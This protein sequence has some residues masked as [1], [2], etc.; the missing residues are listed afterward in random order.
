MCAGAHFAERLGFSVLLALAHPVLLT[1]QFPSGGVIDR[2]YLDHPIGSRLA[3]VNGDALPD[4][5][6]WGTA[7]ARIGWCKNWGAAGWSRTIPLDT[8]ATP[9]VVDLELGDLDGDVDI[10]MVFMTDSGSV[11]WAAN[12]GS[13]AMGGAVLVLPTENLA[14]YPDVDLA[15]MDGDQ[16]LDIVFTRGDNGMSGWSANDG[17]G[18]FGAVSPY[19]WDAFKIVPADM[20]VDGDID[21]VFS[22]G[23]TIIWQENDGT[24]WLGTAHSIYTAG[25]TH[26]WLTVGDIDQDQDPDV[27]AATDA[28]GPDP[29]EV[30]LFT[31]TGNGQAWS[32]VNI[33]TAMMQHGDPELADLNADGDLDLICPSEYYNGTSWKLRI[34]HNNGNGTFGTPTQLSAYWPGMTRV[35]DLDLDGDLDLVLCDLDRA[36]VWQND[37]TAAFTH[38]HPLICN[39]GTAIDYLDIADIDGDGDL[40]GIRSGS[41]TLEWHENDGDQ[42]HDTVNYMTFGYNTNNGAMPLLMHDMDDDGDEDLVRGNSSN[43][44]LTWRKNLGGGAF[45]NSQLISSSSTGIRHLHAADLDGDGHDDLIV[46]TTSKTQWFKYNAADTLLQLPSRPT[47][48]NGN[49]L[50]SFTADLDLD[51]DLDVITCN[52]TG[53]VVAWHPNSGYNSVQLPAVNIISTSADIATVKVGDLDQDGDPDIVYELDAT[54]EVVWRANSG[55]GL[56]AT[57]SMLITGPDELADIEV[58]DR[59]NDGDLDLMVGVENYLT[60][61]HWL[62]MAEN[63]GNAQFGPLTLEVGNAHCPCLPEDMD[64]DG[65][66]DLVHNTWPWHD[67]VWGRND[68]TL[69]TS[70]SETPS[71]LSDLGCYPMPFDAV[72]RVRPASPFAAGTRFLL[73]D[74]AGRTVRQGLVSTSDALMI[75]KQDLRP[76]L[77]TLLIVEPGK[78]NRT[79]KLVVE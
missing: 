32:M 69:S 6:L 77:H 78:P 10:D 58:F 63:L 37:G 50:R 25:T 18:N 76:G 44:V 75:Q 60:Q 30:H 12:D 36:D 21:I 14:P 24:G 79:A 11:L 56:F 22:V 59:D 35:A 66:I 41:E 46:S 29:W 9:H 71:T 67:I 23:G 64:L 13:G 28:G 5:V 1:A 55:T 53:N 65:D 61:T 19:N 54:N 72:T 31:N 27:I 34:Y 57:E 39:T 42:Q 2:E 4:A 3:D 38:Q 43:G 48:A 47:I 17:A 8:L 16:D 73:V 33:A 68:W 74:A 62:G 7:R 26:R 52:Y 45:T 70:V 51:G 20:D 40:D 49:M 15:D